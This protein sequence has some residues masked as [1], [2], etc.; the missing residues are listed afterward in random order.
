MTHHRL[1]AELRQ[2]SDLRVEVVGLDV[3]MDTT[4]VADG[5]ELADR[6]GARSRFQIGVRAAQPGWL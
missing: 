3:E 2:P 6:L 5:L 4:L 1:R